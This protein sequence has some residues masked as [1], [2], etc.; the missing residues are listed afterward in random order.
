MKILPFS[1]IF[2]LNPLCFKK[3]LAN[4]NSFLLTGNILDLVTNIKNEL[5]NITT[6]DTRQ[7]VTKIKHVFD[8][9]HDAKVLSE[10]GPTK[11]DFT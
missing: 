10:K 7:Y 8:I 6:K 1:F 5:I 2:F 9:T 4:S 11:C 3:F